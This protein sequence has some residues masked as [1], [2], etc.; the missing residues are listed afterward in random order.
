MMRNY[1]IVPLTCLSL[2]GCATTGNNVPISQ[3]P[4]VQQVQ[5]ITEFACKFVPTADTVINIIAQGVPSL[6]AAEAIADAICAAVVP[7]KT[8]GVTKIAFTAEK[9]KKPSVAGVPVRG[10]FVK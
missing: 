7:V 10:R 9:P 6:G 2:L 1:L 8:S 4:V 5:A 3:N